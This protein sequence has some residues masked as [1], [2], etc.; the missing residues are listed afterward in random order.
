MCGRLLRSWP[1]RSLQKV[2]LSIEQNSQNQEGSL[3]RGIRPFYNKQN[4]CIARCGCE[5]VARVNVVGRK[6]RFEAGG[7]KAGGSAAKLAELQ[8]PGDEG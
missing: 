4:F 6:D 1:Q 2:N 7:A 8:R 5:V 3:L